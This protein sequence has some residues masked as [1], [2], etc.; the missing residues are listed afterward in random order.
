M[1]L[2]KM[3]TKNTEYEPFPFTH[4]LDTIELIRTSFDDSIK[5]YTQGSCVKFSMILKH[6]YPSGRILYDL[7]HSIFEYNGNYFDING[8]AE[9]SINHI[10][11]ENYG[12]LSA[13][14]T[15]NLKYE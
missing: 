9:K 10:P 1:N 12:I 15:M 3:S 8:F 4:V 5:V 13:Y 6:I 14:K 2:D 7:N 11:L